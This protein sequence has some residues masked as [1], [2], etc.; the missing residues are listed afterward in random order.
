MKNLKRDLK[1][2]WAG[3]LI[4]GDGWTQIYLIW[5]KMTLPGHVKMVNV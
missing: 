5:E 2:N 1:D 3:A 4:L